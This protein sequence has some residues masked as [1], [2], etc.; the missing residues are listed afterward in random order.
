MFESVLSQQG[1][2]I[3]LGA[4]AVGAFGSLVSHKNDRLANW[5]ANAW[6]IIGSTIGIL[7]A[8]QALLLNNTY[9]LDIPISSL[10]LAIFLNGGAGIIKIN[11][12]S[13]FFMLI[14]STVALV[15]SVYALGYVKHFYKKYDLGA[16]GFFYNIFIA[17]MFLVVTANNGLYFLFAWELMSLASYFLVIFERHEPENVKAGFLYFIM[18]HLASGGILLGF[19]L[20]YSIA[21]SFDF[22]MIRAQGSALPDTVLAAVSLLMLLGFGTKAGIIPLHIWLPKAHPA[23]PSHVSALMSGVMIK[24]GIFMIIK[25]FFDVLPQAPLWFGL[26]VLIIG[27]ISSLLGVLYALSEH[28]LKKLLAYHSVENIGIILLGV[29]SA[30]VFMSLGANSLA[31]LALAAALFHTMNHA[32]FK[33]LLF[34]GAGAVVSSTHTRNIEEYGGLIK[35]MPHTALFFLTGAAAIS[36]LPPLNGFASEWMTFQSLFAGI[37][38]VDTTV[39]SAFI[40]ATVSLAFTGG[41]AAAC[42]VKAF[43][44]TFLAKPRSKESEHAKEVAPSLRIGM[45]VLAFLCLILGVLASLVVPYLTGVAKGLAAFKGDF[46]GAVVADSTV[47]VRDSFAALSMLDIFAALLIVTAVVFII[48][49][50]ISRHQKEKIYNTWDCGANLNP[51][52]EIT[53]TSFSR[54]IISIFGGILKPTKQMEIEYQDAHIRYFTKSSTVILS[55]GDIY[56]KYLYNP[57]YDLA[58]AIGDRMKEIQSGNI[59]VYLLY[60]FITIIGLLIWITH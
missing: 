14:I 24:T 31:L 1:F 48:F 40:F 4:F 28:D 32:I 6:A 23:A 46:S 45:A 20:L 44:I 9:I 33:A 29:G 30:L 55:M 13:A 16:F 53:A 54:S 2:F 8:G 36:A 12:L 57:L 35:S 49:D 19:L 37:S 41:L 15:S 51:R 18:T 7:F 60:I 38:Q 59:N 5:W 56:R 26:L 22:D 58:M 17:S 42:F 50:R 39:R 21:G 3:L 52:M 11:A 34:L 43:G 10:P 25:L 27:A 47:L